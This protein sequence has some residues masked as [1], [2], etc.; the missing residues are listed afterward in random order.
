MPSALKPFRD[1]A[2]A[3]PDCG[4]LKDKRA[5]RCRSCAV[6]ASRGPQN[7]CDDCGTEVRRGS[8]RCYDC[9]GNARGKPMRDRF[10]S[11]VVVTEAGCWEW[12]GWHAHGYA[13][14]RHDDRTD[15]RAHRAAFV[16]FVGPIDDGVLVCHTCD[17]R[18]CVNPAH[19]FL[20]TYSDNARDCV[21]K[22][23]HKNGWTSGTQMRPT[24]CK[25]GH[26]L[27]SMA[28]GRRRCCACEKESKR[29]D[30]VKTK[31]QT[32]VSNAIRDGRLLRQPCAT[33][34]APR[35]EA[36]HDDYSRPLDVLWL[37]KTHHTEEH[38]RLRRLVIA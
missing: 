10:L 37:C 8:A 17:N 19:L 20:G 29:R 23:R 32:A 13:Y 3:C 36:H 31:A 6:I 15:W 30:P 25:N 28:S 35:A 21:T 27:P 18:G 9:A 7:L 11:K 5:K 24:H 38:R 14:F 2:D 12:S 22:G 33:C 16:L 34:G 1:G 26:R 4:T